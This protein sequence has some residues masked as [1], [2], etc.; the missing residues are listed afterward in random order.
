MEMR[1]DRLSEILVSD[2]DGVLFSYLL[3]STLC[4]PLCECCPSLFIPVCMRVCLRNGVHVP[5]FVCLPLCVLL[6]IHVSRNRAALSGAPGLHSWS[7]GVFASRQ[8]TIG[9]VGESSV[10]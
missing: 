7:N 10:E 5:S 9:E 4:T 3:R 2:F 1:V 6:A 8:A